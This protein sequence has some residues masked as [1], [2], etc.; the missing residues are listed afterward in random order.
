MTR[1]TFTEREIALLLQEI[2]RRGD[3][4]YDHRLHGVLLVA[5]NLS[6][7]NVAELLD[8]APRTVE[9]WVQRFKERGLLGLTDKARP[10]R[11]SRLPPDDLRLLAAALTQPPRDSGVV[12]DEWDGHT[13]QDWIKKRFGQSVSTRQAQR[14]LRRYG[15]GDQ[16]RSA[17]WCGRQDNASPYPIP[18]ALALR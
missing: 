11:P 5:R 3:S 1:A 13:V 4:R 14:L 16:G 9:Y 8:E 17:K 12:V 6:C 18:V 2:R 10:G 15:P 7:P